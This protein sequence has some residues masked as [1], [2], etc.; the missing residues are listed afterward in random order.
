MS[1]NS[2]VRGLLQCRNSGS[3]SSL[4]LVLS[5]DGGGGCV[6]VAEEVEVEVSGALKSCCCV[7]E[8]CERYDGCGLIK[9]EFI[10]E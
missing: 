6:M 7:C 3:S 4:S 2:K 5:C 1:M 8:I 9:G 10:K